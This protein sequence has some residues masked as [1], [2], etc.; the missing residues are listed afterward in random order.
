[1][2]S[3]RDRMDGDGVQNVGLHQL[4]RTKTPPKKG[5]MLR[6]KGGK[7]EE[8]KQRDMALYLRK[9]RVRIPVRP[10]SHSHVTPG[11]TVDGGSPYMNTF[12]SLGAMIGRDS[13][14]S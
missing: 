10:P 13:A 11:D 3:T 14:R 9:H 12:R 7:K 2:P 5:E 1:M 6:I 8:K 4:I